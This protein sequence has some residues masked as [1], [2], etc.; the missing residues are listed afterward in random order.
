MP[1][2]WMITPPF[3]GGKFATRYSLGQRD[4]WLLGN[5]LDLR[6]GVTIPDDPPIIEAPD[7]PEMV[8]Q[9]GAKAQYDMTDIGG[10]VLRAIAGLIVDELNLLRDDVIGVASQTWDP[11][12]MANATGVTSPAFTVTGA[13]FGDLVDPVAPYTLAGVT[14]T[15]Y[16]SAANTAVIRLH[17]GTG[18][19][20]NLASGSWSVIVRRH[21]VLAPRTLAQ[22][23]TAIRDKIDSGTVD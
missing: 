15:A 17:N 22:A 3:D 2:P 19:A 8:R 16:V 18:G 13:A 14:A 12:N 23:R 11:A 1:S 7:S 21:S 9:I 6:A 4:F 20:V 5:L 10:V